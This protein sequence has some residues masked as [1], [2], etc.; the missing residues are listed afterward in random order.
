[1]RSA[2]YG[3]D[4]DDTRRR[5]LRGLR[6]KWPDLN[7]VPAGQLRSTIRPE[8]PSPAAEESEDTAFQH[9]PPLSPFDILP[10]S[11]VERMMPAVTTRSPTPTIIFA[12]FC[13]FFRGAV[14]ALGNVTID[15]AACVFNIWNRKRL[16]QEAGW[17]RG[18]LERDGYPPGKGR[19]KGVILEG[20]DGGLGC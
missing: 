14:L 9:S 17:L 13:V 12:S 11:I 18:E 15:F 6:G 19:D 20:R 7:H 4:A 16:G 10:A 8:N 3:C 5:L 1:M 2:G